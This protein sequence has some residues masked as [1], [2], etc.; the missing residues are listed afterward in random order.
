MISRET[1]LRFFKFGIIGTA[2]FVVDSL[3]LLFGTKILNIDPYS[4]R[5]ISYLCAATTTWAGNRFFTFSDRPKADIAKQWVV[6]LVLNLVGFAVNYSVY[7]LLVA[8]YDYIH[9]NPVWAVAAGSLAGMV[10]NYVASTRFIFP[11]A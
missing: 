6:F 3:V 9:A 8:N 7:A 10:I 5:V 11:R 2:G 4:A 1:F